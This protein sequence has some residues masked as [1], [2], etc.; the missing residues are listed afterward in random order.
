MYEASS[1]GRRRHS[2][3]WGEAGPGGVSRGDTALSS[4][5]SACR[6]WKGRLDEDWAVPL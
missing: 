5:P 1:P 2:C 6:T 3:D 4:T